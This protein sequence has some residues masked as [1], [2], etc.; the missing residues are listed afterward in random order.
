MR[1]RKMVTGGD[2]EKLG[3]G[4]MTDARWKDFF[5]TM[6]NAGL[7]PKTLDYKSLRR[8]LGGIE[9]RSPQ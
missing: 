2:T 8:R 7:Y 6:S 9:P 1:S 4:A 5:D 3:I